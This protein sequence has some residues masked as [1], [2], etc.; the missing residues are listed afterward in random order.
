M[1]CRKRCDNIRLRFYIK[2]FFCFQLFVCDT[3]EERI[4]K[5]SKQ[6]LVKQ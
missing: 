1:A 3:I 5:Y 4:S 2:Q 6:V